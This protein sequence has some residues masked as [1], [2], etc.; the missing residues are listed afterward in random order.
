MKRVAFLCLVL[1]TIG[2]TQP[3]PSE[4]LDTSH[5]SLPEDNHLMDS[6][7]VFNKSLIVSS[8]S[9]ISFINSANIDPSMS[10]TFSVSDII[11]L[12][13]TQEGGYSDYS[14]AL[15]NKGSG[16][17]VGLDITTFDSWSNTDV[18]L[19]PMTGFSGP[20]IALEGYTEYLLAING[21][22]ITLYYV[23]FETGEDDVTTPQVES[24]SFEGND[25]AITFSERIDPAQITSD[26]IK[27]LSGED[28][29]IG[30]FNNIRTSASWE[31]VKYYIN[32]DASS[33]SYSLII[34]DVSD[35]AGNSMSSEYSGTVIK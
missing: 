23:P 30:D 31:E 25:L 6:A 9:E 18:G 33:G 7:T 19:K 15:Y 32:Y 2:C 22:G 14:F 13:F 8:L 5:G 29:L 24:V 10:S 17:Q 34:N 21:Q 3:L 11:I 20:F 35:L 12:Y 28:E 4:S 27:L 16:E 26:N 1:L